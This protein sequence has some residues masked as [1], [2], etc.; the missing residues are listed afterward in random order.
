M[1]EVIKSLN[2]SAVICIN[3]DYCNDRWNRMVARMKNITPK[4]QRFPAV[5]PTD[6]RVFQQRLAGNTLSPG[7]IGCAFSH[8]DLWSQLAKKCGDDELFLILEDDVFFQNN[9][10]NTVN[11]DLDFIKN[12]LRRRSTSSAT[13]QGLS[14]HGQEAMIYYQLNGAGF[15]DFSQNE[16]PD[17]PSLFSI[18]K[19]AGI[20]YYTGAYIINRIACQKL[21]HQFGQHDSSIVASD[22]MTKWLQETAGGPWEISQCFF[23]YPWIAMQECYESFIQSG[24][25]LD[26]IRDF[27]DTKYFPH[28]GHLYPDAEL[29]SPALP[30]TKSLTLVTMFYD[31]ARYEQN[32][33]RRQKDAYLQYGDFILGLP[34]N[35]VIFTEPDME[36]YLRERRKTM[37]GTVVK[38][39]KMVVVVRP[40]ARLP[41][42]Q[43]VQLVDQMRENW[44]SAT[45]VFPHK[46]T[47]D[48]S[49]MCCARPALVAEVAEWNPFKTTHFGWIDFGCDH[50]SELQQNYYKTSKYFHL[51]KNDKL[52]IPRKNPNNFA[53]PEGFNLRFAS[54]NLLDQILCT[55][56]CGSRRAVTTYAGVF[57]HA[58]R[59]AV[60][61]EKLC[62]ADEPLA[63]WLTILFP[64]LFHSFQTDWPR[65]LADACQEPETTQKPEATP[66]KHTPAFSAQRRAEQKRD[67]KRDYEKFMSA[68]Q[69]ADR[70]AVRELL[71]NILDSDDVTVELSPAQILTLYIEGFARL[72]YRFPEDRQGECMKLAQHHM[73]FLEHCKKKGMGEHVKMAILKLEAIRYNWQFLQNHQ[74]L[75]D[76][77]TV[78]T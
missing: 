7:A 46:L 31:L 35:L 64:S 68:D 62:P 38:D 10:V 16:N 2:V 77:L 11:A 41:F 24:N 55:F 6:G 27:N 14:S 9:W 22:H 37:V 49:L 12:H 73:A 61:S 29:S 48:Y 36:D 53:R 71:W 18:S 76:R 26:V 34:N 33:S 40:F 25:H 52:W 66:Q 58:L 63:T 43:D 67:L 1:E 15:V 32:S 20:L 4:M 65:L 21:V 57:S 44:K 59:H 5:S 23:R 50:I 51:P 47:P 70:I 28:F 54:T 30:E 45:P 19:Q 60:W 39:M 13:P 3:L 8:L 78:V 75:I 72:W 74:G 56:F 17:R 42:F 69:G